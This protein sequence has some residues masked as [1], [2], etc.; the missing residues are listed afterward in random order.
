MGTTYERSEAIRLLNERLQ[1]IGTAMLTT[2]EPDGSLLSR[3]MVA[4]KLPFDGELWFLARS[5]SRLVWDVQRHTRVSL[6]YVAPTGDQFLAVSGVA[7]VVRDRMKASQLWAEPYDSW[8]AG[9]V[10]DPDLVL[11]RVSVDSAQAWG[12][13][14][15][16]TERFEAL[17]TR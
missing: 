12:F 5:N 1:G 7:H 3:P 4:Q 6:N 14:P 15:G 11:I 8:F 2:M 16:V 17:A 13:T 9:G 10:D